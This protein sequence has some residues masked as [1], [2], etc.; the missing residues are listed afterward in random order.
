M[1]MSKCFVSQ[2]QRNTS[3]DHWEKEYRKPQLENMQSLRDLEK[4]TINR[5]PSSNPS[6]QSTGNFEEEGA[7][8]F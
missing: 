8:R 7:E 3:C 5:L 6:S 2:H 4:C 1:L